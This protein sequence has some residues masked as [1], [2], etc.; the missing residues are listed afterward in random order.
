[1]GEGKDSHCT[2]QLAIC[3][4]L[5]SQAYGSFQDLVDE[6]CLEPKKLRQVV[7]HVFLRQ[8]HPDIVQSTADQFASSVSV[9]SFLGF[10]I[11]SLGWLPPC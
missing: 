5:M 1:M 3:N 7:H 10:V 2:A 4:A 6:N 9:I 8:Y 11:S